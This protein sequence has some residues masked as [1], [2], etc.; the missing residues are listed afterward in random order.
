M[1]GVRRIGSA[2][3]ALTVGGC[4]GADLS[5]L[6]SL[7]DNATESS[8][9]VVPLPTAH[10]ESGFGYGAMSERSPFE[11]FAEVA[12]AGAS[13]AP[14]S[15]RTPQPQ[16]FFPLGQLEMVGTLTG[17]GKI[18]ALI[19]DP[20]GITRPLA[21]GDYLGRDHGRITAIRGSGIDILELVEDGQGGWTARA[22]ALEL[23]VDHGAEESLAE[24]DNGG[25]KE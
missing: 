11:P 9:A 2:A 12:G 20:L 10:G 15:A 6:E 13:N 7:V 19:R 14:D 4:N 18:L 1:T 17:R 22:R 23:A 8:V 24:T 25:N 3:L 16:E 21:V 5:D